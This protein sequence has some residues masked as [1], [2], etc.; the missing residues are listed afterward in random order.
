MWANRALDAALMLVA[1]L[2]IPVQLVTTFVLGILVSVTFGLLLFPMSLIWIVCFLGPLL[3]LSWI[4]EKAPLLRIPLAVVGIPLA[5][6]GNIYACLM[7]SM[8]ELDS[9]VSKLLLSESWPYSLDCWRLIKTKSLPESP[10]AEQFR[11]ILAE[12]SQKNRP[13]LQYLE[14]LGV[15]APLAPTQQAEIAPKVEDELDSE[16]ESS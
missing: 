14:S 2:V 12:V 11:R 5:F 7:P 4:W 6:V 16:L 13:Y 15:M 10:G 3:G 8:G 1:W 9:R